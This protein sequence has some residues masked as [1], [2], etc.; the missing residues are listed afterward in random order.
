[1][2]HP[3]DSPRTPLGLGSPGT[4]DVTPVVKVSGLTAADV[5]A[6]NAGQRAAVVGAQSAAVKKHGAFNWQVR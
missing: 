5:A 3:H 4:P 1:M 6:W 2:P